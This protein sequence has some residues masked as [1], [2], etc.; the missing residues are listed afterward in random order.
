MNDS[1]L[2]GL[3][4]LDAAHPACHLAATDRRQCPQHGRRLD[5]MSAEHHRMRDFVV[6]RNHADGEALSPESIGK[7]VNLPVDQVIAYPGRP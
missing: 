6:D 2:L 7:A 3:V 4:T 5:F 1:L